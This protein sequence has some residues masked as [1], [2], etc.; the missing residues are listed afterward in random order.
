MA[1]TFCAP[2]FHPLLIPAGLALPFSRRGTRKLLSKVIAEDSS[3]IS[4]DTTQWHRYK[5]EW[6]PQGVAWDVDD[7]LV[8]ESRVSPNPPLGTHYLD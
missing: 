1:Q 5:L 6:S 7:I 2:K 8:F 3:V 4:V